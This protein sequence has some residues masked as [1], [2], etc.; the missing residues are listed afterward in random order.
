MAMKTRQLLITPAN[1]IALTAFLALPIP[2]LAQFDASTF[3]GRAPRP[4]CI[5]KGV[6]S[7]AEIEVCTG[8]RVRYNYDVYPGPT[9]ARA[10]YGG[11]VQKVTYSRRAFRRTR[12]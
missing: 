11:T 1:A 10:I 3:G 2:S 7:D 12:N 9:A 6:M 5:Y 8:F 4:V